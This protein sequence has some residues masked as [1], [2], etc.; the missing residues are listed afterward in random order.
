MKIII[1]NLC[2]KGKEMEEIIIEVIIMA[3]LLL[4]P[5]WKIF[6]RAGLNPVL[7]LTVLIPY[8]GFLISGIILAAST[9]RLGSV[10]QGKN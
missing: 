6:K 2:A 3:V 7:S 1:H 5:V 9:W 4:F 10:A 8:V